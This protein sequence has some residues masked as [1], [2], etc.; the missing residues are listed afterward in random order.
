MTNMLYQLFDY[1]GTR[2][3]KQDDAILLA[4]NSPSRTVRGGE[5]LIGWYSVS[6]AYSAVV[7]RRGVDLLQAIVA[8]LAGGP[9]A[10]A[11]GAAIAASGIMVEGLPLTVADVV[12]TIEEFQ[13]AMQATKVDIQD[14]GVR[15]QVQQMS[16]L[17]SAAF[18]DLPGFVDA[19]LALGEVRGAPPARQWS[20]TMALPEG[21]DATAADVAAA[22]VAGAARAWADGCSNALILP[23]A[24][25]G[26]TL[27]EIKAAFMA[28]A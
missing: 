2:D 1:I 10:D 13:G 27:A 11:I 19:L 14:A 7:K 16:D 25:A 4:I 26:S 6:A 12:G 5:K 8:T 9:V 24:E 3:S 21:R 17:L 15:G 22:R 23:M 20:A 28:R 18:P